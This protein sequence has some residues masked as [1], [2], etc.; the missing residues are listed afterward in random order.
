[1]VN[2]EVE[3]LGGFVGDS[4]ALPAFQ[5]GTLLTILIFMFI[6]DWMLGLSCY[7]SL[8]HPGL[9]HSKA[10]MACKSTR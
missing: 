8:S 9:H 5:G 4:I 3:P 2:S 6:Q 1:M 7:R 10:T